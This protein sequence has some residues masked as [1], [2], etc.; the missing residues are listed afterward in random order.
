MMARFPLDDRYEL[1]LGGTWTDITGYVRDVDPVTITRGQSAEAQE[2]DPCKLTLKLDNRDGRFSPRNPVGAWYGLLGRNTRLRASLP[3]PSY[4]DLPD[5]LTGYASAPDSAALSVTGDLD[6]R[7]EADLDNW[8][9]DADLIGKAQLPAG[10]ISWGLFTRTDGDLT[11]Y[12]S[13]DGT[14]TVNARSTA[15]VPVTGRGRLAVRATLDVNNGASGWTVRFYI[16][17]R[18]DGT[19]TQLGADITG[20]GVT[21][22]YDGTAPVQVGKT[23]NFTFAG[24]SGRVFSAEIRDGIN[25]TLVA[26]PDFTAQTAGDTSFTDDQAN[27]WTV[28]SPAALNDRM[29]RFHGEVA[30]WPATWDMSGADSYVSITAAGIKRRLTQNAPTLRSAMFRE[31]SNPARENI[32]VYWP[33]ED[34]AEATQIAASNSAASPMVV[35]GAP[36]LG[37]NS[38]WTSSDPLPVMESGRLTGTTPGHVFTGENSI[39]L[40][41]WVQEN[42]PVETSLLQ[43]VCVGGTVR[44][45]DVRLDS[46]GAL[47]TRAYDANGNS[48]LDSTMAFNMHTL[49]FTILDLELTQSG[50]NVAGRT[51]VIEFTGGDTIRDSIPILPHNWTLTGRTFGSTHRVTVG[52]NGGL[53]K[54]VVGHLAVADAISA[55]ASTSAAMAAYNGENP[56]NRMRR[57]AREE[58]IEFAAVGMART[59]NLVTLGDQL[60]QTL[61]ELL[62]EAADSDLGILYEPRDFLGFAYRSRLSLYNQ[63]PAVT[64]DYSA[65]QVAGDLTP[66]DDDR[67]V[68]NDLTAERVTGSSVR[69]EETTGPLSVAEPP[70]GVGRYAGKAT[71]SLETDAQLSDQAGWRLHLGTVDEARFPTLTVNLRATGITDTMYDQILGLDVGDRIVLT[72]IPAGLPPDDVSLLVQGYTETLK[73]NEHEITFNLVPES[74]WHIG[75]VD[76]A[77]FDRLDTPGSEL[78]S[79]V[80]ADATT[81][82][83]APTQ[84]VWW[85]TDPTDVPFNIRASGEV[86]TVTAIGDAGDDVADA[87]SV[88]VSNGWG[89]TDTGQAWTVAAGAASDFSAAN[90]TG[91]VIASSTTGVERGIVVPV[92]TAHQSV[93]FHSNTNVIPTGAAITWGAYLRWSD[94]SNYYWVGVEI[95]LD[96]SLTLRIRKRVAG[97]LTLLASAV[98]ATGHV[99][100]PWRVLKAEAIGSII[101]A[102]VWSA[103]DTEPAGWEI[104]TTDTD[105]TSGGFAGCV[106]RR[107]TGSTNGTSSA[108]D[109]F[110]ATPQVQPFTVTRSTNGVSKAQSAGTAVSLAEPVFVAL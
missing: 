11:L 25:G 47:R 81:L 22:I 84:A 82:V 67:S 6:V 110:A 106:V 70:D 71:L 20:S 79:P 3:G 42:P 98:S 103:A 44:T 86:M 30:S 65:R 9:V 14:T 59:G 7:V 43:V 62:Q 94:A 104:E 38:E 19:W 78:A 83:V 56:T 53:G 77:G 87:F 55:Y 51:L 69:A 52:Q 35:T 58:E 97:T 26:S 75:Q 73:L 96:A 29:Y 28:H 31:F 8:T 90:S 16:A 40:F 68:I 108:F 33:M 107:E 2:A 101:R 54:V 1:L 10:Q 34:G 99:T 89:S 32:L 48:L 66:V 13:V 100:S 85:T 4:L 46:T 72:G 39:R 45:I 63:D 80:D 93:L 76:T 95:G 88:T 5:T 57:L 36:E 49:G 64:L 91:G 41:V 105:L 109:L 61:V 24:R 15:A 27:T 18:I 60:N 102:K 92:G 74:P 37:S 23:P 17:S 50:S 21:S 12:W